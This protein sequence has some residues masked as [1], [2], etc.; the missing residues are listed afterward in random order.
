[1][2]PISSTVVVLPLVPVTAMSSV[3]EQTPGELELAEHRQPLLAG[4]GDDRRLRGHPGALDQRP[5]AL[6]QLEPI[7][8]QVQLDAR[9]DKR[10]ESSGRAPIDADRRL[11]AL[12][13][14]ERGRAAGAREPYDQI[15]ALGQGRPGLE[16]A[17]GAAQ[18]INGC[19]GDR[20]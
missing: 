15:G 6:Q 8:G 3:L 16:G 18:R 17:R 1:M 9:G 20:W 10:V 11:A 19:S 2:C 14:R 12:A 4:R 13:Q 7:L 5:D